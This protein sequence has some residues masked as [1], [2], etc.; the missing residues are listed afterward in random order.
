MTHPSKK[1]TTLPPSMKSEAAGDGFLDWIQR[2]EREWGTE[3]YQN[4][5][6]LADLLSSPV[7]SFWKTK[8]GD[9]FIIIVTDDISEIAEYVRQIAVRGLIAPPTRQLMRVFVK[10]R[11]VRVQEVR[12]EFA[13][14]DDNSGVF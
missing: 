9:R 1:L 11:P 7:V 4:R 14:E 5:P 10:Q 2:H 8:S 6:G 3:T 13:F 12:V